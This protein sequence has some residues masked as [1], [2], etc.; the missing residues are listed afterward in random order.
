MPEIIEKTG[1]PPIEIDSA[2]L[3]LIDWSITGN[4]NGVGHLVTNIFDGKLVNKKRYT[5]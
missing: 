1:L 5:Y 3:N 4:A 2:G